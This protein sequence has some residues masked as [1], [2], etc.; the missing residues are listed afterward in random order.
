MGESPYL[1]QLG[2]VL[3]NGGFSGTFGNQPLTLSLNCEFLKGWIYISLIL[4]GADGSQNAVFRLASL[5]T[6]GILY[7]LQILRLNLSSPE[8]EHG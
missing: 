5:A 8:S 6:S 4:P 3:P 7:E 2:F 1:I